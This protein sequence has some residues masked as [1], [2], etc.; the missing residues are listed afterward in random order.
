MNRIQ[1]YA[2]FFRA[3][4]IFFLILTPL[5]TG[6]IWFSGGEINLEGESAAMVLDMYADGNDIDPALLPDTPM[7]WETR[8]MGLAVSI[9]PSGIAMVFLWWLIQLFSSF[10]RGEVFTGATVRHIRNLGWT[11][12]V[13][14]ISA[15]IYDAL[16]SYTLTM[17]NPPGERIISIGLD[18]TEFEELI[19]AG[20]IILIS[21]VME[22]G[23][24]LRES[25]ELTV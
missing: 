23:R 8:L 5:F 10:A 11:M 18:S 20:I 4:F 12:I 17:H 6:A 25:D 16:I 9:L 21:W 7:P 13:G 14:V 24:K 22:E 3:I 2:K 1:R 19:M 15:P